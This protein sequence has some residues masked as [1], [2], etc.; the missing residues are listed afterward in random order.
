MKSLR[1]TLMAVAALCS[2]ALS[3]TPAAA[4]PFAKPAV[5]SDE[6][7]QNVAFVCGPFRC[8]WRPSYYAP[9]YGPAYVIPYTTGPGWYGGPGWGG[10]WRA[11]WYGGWRPGWG[12]GWYRRGWW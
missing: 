8:W 7:V 1:F 3:V 9:V 10:G 2:G 11:G 4:M 5:A 12:G 6:A